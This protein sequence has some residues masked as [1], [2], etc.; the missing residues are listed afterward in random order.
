MQN[1]AHEGKFRTLNQICLVLSK[2]EVEENKHVL[3]KAGP[4]LS[5]Q[6]PLFPT[7]TACIL[8]DYTEQ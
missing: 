8:P 3:M 2:W 1:Q 5:S 4:I 6:T 7:I